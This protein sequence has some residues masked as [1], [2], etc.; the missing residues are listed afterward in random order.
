ML[1]VPPDLTKIIEN[2]T[3]LPPVT[4]GS[5]PFATPV[6]QRLQQLVVHIPPLC[7][8]VQRAL[9][10]SVQEAARAYAT[11]YALEK[12][13]EEAHKALNSIKN[14]MKDAL[15]PNAFEFEGVTNVPLEEG[16]RVGVQYKV[17]ASIRGG[18]KDRALKHLRDINCG[19]LISLTVNASSLSSLASELLKEDNREL[20]AEVF[21]VEVMPTTSITWKRK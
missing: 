1:V 2:I 5:L 16:L 12:A 18:Q 13:L 20:P 3:K 17:R 8:D 7:D 19:D 6:L 14:D 4:A 9:R 21:S 10:G 11:V 15:I